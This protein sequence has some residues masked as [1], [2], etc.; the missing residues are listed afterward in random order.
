MTTKSTTKTTSSTTTTNESTAVKTATP[1]IMD[2]A[3]AFISSGGR[4]SS[5]VRQAIEA[6]EVE[7]VLDTG[8]P[9]SKKNINNIRTMTHAVKKATGKKFSVRQPADPEANVVVIR[10]S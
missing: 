3:P 7:Q 8:V 4:T 5:P 10:V 1:K 6:M 9:F 2:E